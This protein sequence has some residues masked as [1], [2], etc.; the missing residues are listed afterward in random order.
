MSK[1]IVYAVIG[2]IS[3][4]EGSEPI[5]Y[6]VYSKESLAK[7]VKTIAGSFTRVEPIEV[8]HIA[9]GWLEAFKAYGITVEKEDLPE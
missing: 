7:K 1:P 4:R 8:D 2:S 9:P 5:L 6:G 3:D